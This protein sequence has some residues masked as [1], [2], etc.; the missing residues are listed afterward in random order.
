MSF[1]KVGQVPESMLLLFFLA[2]AS[3]INS[4]FLR[5]SLGLVL[6]M[7][8]KHYEL[9]GKDG[10]QGHA[11][12][13]MIVPHRDLAYQFKY[14][15]ERIWGHVPPPKQ[16]LSNLVQVL[17]R[18]SAFP[19]EQQVSELHSRRP[20]IVITTPQA[21]HDILEHDDTALNLQKI[22][23]VVVDEVDYLIETLPTSGDKYTKAK[24]MRVMRRHPSL[25][26]LI[27]ERIYETGG[28]KYPQLIMATATLRT[29]LRYLVIVRSRWFRDAQIARRMTSVTS[30]EEGSQFATQRL[31]KAITY[32]PNRPS[33]HH[34]ALVI[35]PSGDVSNIG[36]ATTLP[37][38]EDQVKQVTSSEGR[39]DQSTSSSSV[40]MDG[41]MQQLLDVPEVVEFETTTSP[42]NPDALEA[43]AAAFA[44]DVPRVALLVL[45]PM[46]AVQRCIYELR[47]MGINAHGVDLL[48]K[49]GGAAYLLRGGS[50]TVADNPALLVTTLAAVRGIDL[51]DLS[52]VFMLGI[53]EDQREDSYVHVA[54]RV[55]RAG[56]GGKVITVL[57]KQ[58]RVNLPKGKV[59]WQDEPQIMSRLFQ[60]LRI[61]PTKFAHFP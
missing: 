32:S 33:V 28:S 23:T 2:N 38:E 24:A 5:R 4:I 51:P 29:P 60:S 9:R 18:N 54:G 30:K 41:Q 22:A 52:H 46:S 7:L 58:R 12:S 11:T 27:L 59:S 31:Q 39:I 50:T 6:A 45:Q 26:R 43:I 8:S 47:K 21:L 19:L 57:E 14:W 37:S 35:A 40:T 3:C 25:T 44:L 16:Q 49:E 34:H 42:F 48:Q 1:F 53:P 17:A 36:M 55:G 10:E 13:L 15:I 61:Q 56:Q 20:E